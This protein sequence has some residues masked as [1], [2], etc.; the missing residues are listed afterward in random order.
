MKPLTTKKQLTALPRIFNIDIPDSLAIEI[1][2]CR[3][4]K[5]A[6]IIGEKWCIEQSKQLLKGGVQCLHFYTMSKVD[7]FVRIAKEVL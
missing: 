1:E 2:K 3:D 4:D 5:E 7:G 6:T